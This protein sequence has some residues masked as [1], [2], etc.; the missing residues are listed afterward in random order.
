MKTVNI[1][2]KDSAMSK[3]TTE[4]RTAALR[5]GILVRPTRSFDTPQT[6]LQ[7]AVIEMA[8]LGFLINIDDIK[9][10]SNS[11]LETM[12][13]DARTVTG[14]DRN[15]RPIYPGFPQQVKNL[16]TLTLLF[17]QLMH[18][19]SFGTLLPNYPD[20]VRE[21]LPLAD[22]VRTAREV[23]VMTAGAAARSLI[24]TLTT[25]RVAL[26]EDEQ[27]LLEGS[28]VVANP[29]LNNIIPAAQ[30]A[31]NGENLQA[32]VL[33]MRKNIT[34][35][36]ANDYV[37][38]LTPTCSNLDQVLRLILAVATEPAKGWENNYNLAVCT[39]ADRHSRAV[40][41]INL[42]RPARRALMGRVSALSD[43]FKADALV[44]RQGL[45]RRVMRMVHPYDLTLDFAGKRAADIIHSNMEYRTFNSRV[46]KAMAAADVD[47]AVSLLAENQ[48]GNLLR[49]L[50][51][52]LRLVSNS[53]QAKNLA[54]AVRNTGTASTVTT[55]VSAYN[56]I[57]SVNDSN[58]RVTRVAGLRNT[59]R[60][61]DTRPIDARYIAMVAE[62]LKDAL[63]SVLAT[64]SA[65]KG[66]VAVVSDQAVPLVRRDLSATDRV[67]DR[68]QEIT[69][70]GKGD[71]VRFFG[72]WVNNQ[73]FA[74]YLDIGVVVLDADFKI[75]AV[76]TWNSWQ[77][78]RDWSTYSGD[79]QVYPG[80]DAAE[81]IDVDLA[82]LRKKH[83]DARLIAMTLQS[84]GGF[85]L[86][87]LDMIAG[88]MLRSKPESGEVFDPRTVA[89]AFRPTTSSTQAI[90]FAIDL[91]T[92]K[93]VWLDSSNGSTQA[94]MSAADDDTVGPIVY[95]EL[96]RPRM[97][98]GELATLW[99]EAHG[100]DTI[101]SPVDKDTLLDL[102]N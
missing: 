92:G 18:Y 71:T 84:W 46:E 91:E 12:L 26:S 21:G 69:P 56:G 89:T 78:A 100:V 102:L 41:M 45:W 38:A 68:G 60:E 64:K 79:K 30:K 19:W 62:A 94:H 67:L 59:L 72:H 17:E 37:L 16:D 47:T 98:L 10:M 52:L 96:A 82:A 39:L 2:Q 54:D 58:A 85:P 11:A 65:P 99:A 8:N 23:K 1:N 35:I 44:T 49:R 73:R 29:S 75:I 86:A 5:N 13:K 7:A 90:P 88:A 27:T 28:V 48:P 80:D 83:K 76:S 53:R 66:A 40:R 34:G 87:N 4:F 74:S 57:I 15:M 3:I 32:L 22:M 50:A 101:D 55:L 9:G 95:D 20:V 63:K 77:N 43:G 42:S 33:A 93:M 31:T 24:Y 6:T 36:S 81:Y 61:V 14:A 97:T 51:A 25:R 70:A